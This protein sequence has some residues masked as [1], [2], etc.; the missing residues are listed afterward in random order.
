MFTQERLILEDEITS[1]I[2]PG[3]DGYFGVLAHHAPLVATLGQG[4]VRVKKFDDERTYGIS[5]GFV[6]VADNVV[7]ILADAVSEPLEA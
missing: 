6:E 2:L 7:T 5:G 1:L 3:A 4:T